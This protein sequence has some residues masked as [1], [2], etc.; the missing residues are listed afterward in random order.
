MSALADIRRTHGAAVL[1]VYLC[2]AHA[3]DAWPLSPE[4]P[5]CHRSLEERQAA[6]AA[7]LGR[8]PDFAGELQGCYVD[9]MDDGSTLANGLW[10]ERYLV[11]RDGIV[12]WASSFTEDPVQQLKSAVAAA[13]T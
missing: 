13:F 4:A 5:R 3:V 10:P 2:E 7:F 8:W 9:G 6:A 1:F 12:V 11:V